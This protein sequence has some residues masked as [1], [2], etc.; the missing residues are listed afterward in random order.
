MSEFSRCASYILENLE[1]IRSLTLRHYFDGSL[2]FALHFDD[3]TKSFLFL[4]RDLKRFEG[5]LAAL[6]SLCREGI[7]LSYNRDLFAKCLTSFYEEY[8]EAK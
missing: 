6:E 5:Y 1:R 2:K 4:K 7:K 8:P 3:G